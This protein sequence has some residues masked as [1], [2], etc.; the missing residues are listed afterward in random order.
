MKTRLFFFFFIIGVVVFLLSTGTMAGDDHY[1]QTS[2]QVSSPVAVF[3]VPQV[4][5]RVDQFPVY[6]HLMHKQQP[7]THLYIEQLLYGHETVCLRLVFS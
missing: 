7:N 2:T 4:L 3:V 6:R 1:L 5:N